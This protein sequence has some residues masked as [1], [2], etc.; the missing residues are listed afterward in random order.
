MGGDGARCLMAR[1]VA[2]A[3]CPGRRDIG[4]RAAS[5]GGN[6]AATRERRFSRRLHGGGGGGGDAGGG[7]GGDGRDRVKLAPAAA[8]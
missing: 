3:H 4:D 8:S 1:D 2:A 7:G 5:L 6:G